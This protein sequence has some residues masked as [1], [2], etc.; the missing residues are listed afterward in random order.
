ML[1]LD[2]CGGTAAQSF[3][4]EHTKA[5]AVCGNPIYRKDVKIKNGKMYCKFC[6]K[7]T[8]VGYLKNILL[9]KLNENRAVDGTLFRYPYDENQA[10]A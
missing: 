5:C 1:S 7:D 8:K 2:V 9:K 3:E 6:K 10:E 4:F